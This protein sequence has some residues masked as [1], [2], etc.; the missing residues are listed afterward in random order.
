MMDEYSGKYGDVPP[1]DD[2]SWRRGMEATL[3]FPTEQ[4][5]FAEVKLLVDSPEDAIR[6][7]NMVKG[8]EGVDDKTFNAFLDNMILGETNHIEVYE[9][10]SAPQKDI[11]QAVKR[12]IKRLKARQS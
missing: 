12:S 1:G 5:G 10:M 6:Q 2:P 9:K 7:Y 11:V 8:G 4:Y 3:H